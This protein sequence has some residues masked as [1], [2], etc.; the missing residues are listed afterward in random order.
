MTDNFSNLHEVKV[1]LPPL[2]DL[3]AAIQTEVDSFALA[4]GNLMDM[5]QRRNKAKFEKWVEAETPF[6]LA[7]AHRL[8]R[9]FVAYRD[10]PAESE[11]ELPRPSS[12]LTYV[13]D[14]GDTEPWLS[15]TQEFSRED[16]LVGALLGGHPENVVGDLRK[17]LASW[18]G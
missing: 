3:A 14:S 6:T 4:I 13:L 12:A 17:R 8:R 2:E 18:L 10:L 7:E 9:I 1:P 16:L 15:P 11:A 5:A